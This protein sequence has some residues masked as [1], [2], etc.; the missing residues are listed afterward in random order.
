MS[1]KIE[2]KVEQGTTELVIREAAALTLREPKIVNI[3]G[4]IGAPAE[5]LTKRKTL[6]DPKKCNVVFS[7]IGLYIKLTVNESD[8]YAT[9]IEGKATLNPDLTKFGINTGKLYTIKELKQ[10]LKMNRV[11]FKEVDS[12][13]KMV[14]NLERF[15]ASVQTQIDN[16]STDR[17]DKK[18]NLEV[19]IDSNL[20]LNFVLELPIFIGENPVSFQVEVCCDIRDGATSIWLESPELQI[21]I[22]NG[23]EAM[24]TANIEDFKAD[25]VVIEQ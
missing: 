14:T 24:I 2:V 18:Q 23:R 15:S 7:Y 12:N 1:D 17:G 20:D 22:I 6:I 4:T 11:F 13:L 3:I 25:F 21:L 8:Y 19:K 9:C 16:H 5:Y 10:F